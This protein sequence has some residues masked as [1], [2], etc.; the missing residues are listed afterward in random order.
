MSQT[1]Q[2]DR[3]NFSN[4][5]RLARNLKTFQHLQWNEFAQFLQV[6]KSC[7]ISGSDRYASWSKTRSPNNSGIR[8]SRPAFLNPR[9]FT[10][11]KSK[12]AETEDKSRILEMQSLGNWLKSSRVK[13]EKS[14]KNSKTSPS[15]RILF[16]PSDWPSTDE[17]VSFIRKLPLRSKKARQAGR[18]KSAKG[19][20]STKIE[21][22]HYKTFQSVLRV[23]QT[24]F[25]A[26]TN[27]N[28]FIHQNFIKSEFTGRPCGCFVLTELPVLVSKAKNSSSSPKSSKSS[29]SLLPNPT[30]IINK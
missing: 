23:S 9:C 28:T 3:I 29:L 12:S 11:V 26:Q 8:S 1:S 15:S 6:W 20:L 22:L 21:R 25:T 27:R 10:R 7:Q 16:P 17:F 14:E 24:L 13:S 2:C 4:F 5:C 18:S 30:V 19:L